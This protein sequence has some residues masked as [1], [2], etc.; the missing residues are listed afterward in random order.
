[1]NRGLGT[2][3]AL[4]IVSLG[5]ALLCA[6]AGLRGLGITPDD[7]YRVLPPDLHVVFRPVAG[8]MPGVEGEA[9]YV[10]NSEGVRGDPIPEAA[11]YRIL[12]VGGSTTECLFLDQHEAWPQRL[13]S[14]LSGERPLWVGNVGR[15]GDHTRQHMFQVDKLLAQAPRVD[16]L[17]LLVGA[18]DLL[19]RLA[20]DDAYVPLM[21]EPREQF[22][23]TLERSFHRVPQAGALPFWRRTAL[24]EAVVRA[25]APAPT[26]QHAA[27]VQ[28]RA[29]EI[30]MTWRAHRQ[31][32]PRLRDELPDLTLALEEFRRNVG[33]IVQRARKSGT[34]AILLTQPAL[35][36]D[37]L[38]PDQEALLW[39]GG[40]GRFQAEPGHEYYTAGALAAG[41]ARYNDVLRDVC[42][43]TGAE[44]VD[45]ARAIPSDTSAFYDGVHFNEA[46]AERVAAV[47][48][49]HLLAHPPF[50]TRTASRP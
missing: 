26:E 37:D 36:R 49:E 44:C 27:E 5:V 33:W 40:V 7:G 13:Q 38:P 14:D 10:T 6:E 18:N 31:G 23:R 30:Y 17:L 39:L 45:L 22:A 2:R 43:Q 11:A 41:L 21:Q 8:L 12:A 42:A 20:L 19:Y 32:S 35:W 46:G 48:A 15:S 29:G 50:A 28:D 47:V 3:V 34:R 9:H 16:A 1:V 24:A 4:G 25:S